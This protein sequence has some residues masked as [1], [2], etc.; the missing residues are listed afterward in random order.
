MYTVQLTDTWPVMA[1]SV[2]DPVVLR[3]IGTSQL[4]RVAKFERLR[5]KGTLYYSVEYKRASKMN[6]YTVTYIDNANTVNF[7]KIHYFLRV[8]YFD[9]ESE[10]TAVVNKFITV[11]FVS[12]SVSVPHLYKVV[13]STKVCVNSL[14]ISKHCLF[15]NTPTPYIAV[16]FDFCTT[17]L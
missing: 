13:S 11:P 10:V 14:W 17:S 6:N 16:P 8:E 1:S 12:T 4:K 9:K 5:V 3:W 2:S 7:A 15:I